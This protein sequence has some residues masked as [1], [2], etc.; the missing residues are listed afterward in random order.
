MVKQSLIRRQWSMACNTPLWPLLGLTGGRIGPDPINRLVIPSHST[1]IFY[2]DRTF[3]SAFAA[4]YLLVAKRRWLR[5]NCVENRNLTSAENLKLATARKPTLN[6]SILVTYPPSQPRRIRY[7]LGLFT[8]QVG[9]RGGWWSAGPVKNI[10]HIW[11]LQTKKLS[12]TFQNL[13]RRMRQQTSPDSLLLNLWR[14]Y[15]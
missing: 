9:I 4:S 6:S 2:S 7:P 5:V 8:T 14:R 10:Q 1:Y 3:K 15:A 11:R 12:G 13:T